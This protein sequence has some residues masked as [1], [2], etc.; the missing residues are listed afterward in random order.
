MVKSTTSRIISK[1]GFFIVILG[2]YKPII[3]DQNIFK[4][5]EI[6]ASLSL[7]LQNIAIM[8]ESNFNFLDI[9]SIIVISLSAI[10]AFS[11]IGIILFF[12]L[13]IK[14][15]INIYIDWVVI[16][17]STISMIIFCSMISKILQFITKISK[18]SAIIGLLLGTN[19]NFNDIVFK[20]LQ[21][22]AFFIISGLIISIFFNFLASFDMILIPTLKLIKKIRRETKSLIK[23]IENKYN[24]I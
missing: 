5:S 9:S 22:G 2:F 14:K 21:T 6:I 15:N 7:E 12:L 10:F 20:N 4:I 8:L 1:A 11:H 18:V 17:G 24:E 19:I 13:I 3:F 23:D 16:L